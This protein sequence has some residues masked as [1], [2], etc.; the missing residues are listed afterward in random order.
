MA[1][2]P[3]R[4]HAGCGVDAEETRQTEP[5]LRL[6]CSSV[7]LGELGEGGAPR[8]HVRGRCSA[9][10]DTKHAGGVRGTMNQSG[11]SMGIPSLGEILSLPQSRLWR[12]RSA[13]K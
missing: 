1:G 4:I 9:G 10:S 6:I 5:V 11:E 2:W 3:R 12:C 13:W 7:Q 8:A